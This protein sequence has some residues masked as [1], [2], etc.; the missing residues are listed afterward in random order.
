MK[1][2][3]S[4][5]SYQEQL[6]QL[7]DRGMYVADQTRA[8]RYL[9]HLN[10][11]RLAAYWLPFE[12][13][14]ATHRFKSGTSFDQVLESYIFDK[15]LRLLIMDAIERFEVSLRTQWT[16]HLAH[17]YGPHAHLDATN[18]KPPSQKPKWAH[19]QSVAELRDTVRES[20]EVFIR[21][22]KTKY[23]E[24]LP[25][26]WATC[27]I[28]TFGELSRWYANLAKSGDRNAI[29][30]IYDYDEVYFVSFIHH[31]TIVR[32]FTAHHARVWNREF[33]LTW[34]LPLSKPASVIGSLNRQDGKRIYNTLAMLACLI[35][36]INPGNHWKKR[37]SDL[38]NSY[39]GIQTR[40]MGFPGNWRDLPLWKGKV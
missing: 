31:L 6:K 21:H 23:D 32:N 22:L 30:R 10:Y 37:L 12:A 35:D 40:Y 28:M 20:S 25:P 17:Q 33:P 1:Y 19:A 39:P 15:Q 4:P 29:A 18:F 7:I 5:K 3:K 24:E 27:E 26:I 13:D 14:H 8:L 38:I 16:Y 2:P 36:V 9:S 34:K 11:Y